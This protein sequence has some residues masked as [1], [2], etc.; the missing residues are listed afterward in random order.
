M[1]SE[2]VDLA[3][4]ALRLSALGAANAS[5]LGGL[6]GPTIKAMFRRLDNDLERIAELHEKEIAAHLA[7]AAQPVEAVAFRG[8]RRGVFL[9]EVSGLSNYPLDPKC[10]AGHANCEWRSEIDNAGTVRRFCH[11]CNGYMPWLTEY[12]ASAFDDALAHPRPT[13]DVVDALVRR[14]G[15]EGLEA[16]PGWKTRWSGNGNNF[17]ECLRNGHLLNEFYDW[18]GLSATTSEQ[19][20]EVAWIDHTPSGVVLRTLGECKRL[21]DLPHGTK[22]YTLPHSA[23]VPGGEVGR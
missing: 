18:L 16:L 23:G 1:K 7:K 8:L 5:S 6:D 22:L 13:G 11:E 2:T 10:G 4:R 3:I 12:A 20:G 17:E 15:F 19:A 9:N 21:E 14:L